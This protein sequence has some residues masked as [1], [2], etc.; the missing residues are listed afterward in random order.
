[1]IKY[2]KFPTPHQ[3]SF[4]HVQCCKAQVAS[5]ATDPGTPAVSEGVSPVLHSIDAGKQKQL[6]KTV[7]VVQKAPVAQ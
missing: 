1:M 4:L 7:E 3:D 2:C 5:L 6:M